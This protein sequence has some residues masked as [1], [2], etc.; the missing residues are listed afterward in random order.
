MILIGLIPVAKLA[1]ITNQTTRT[2]KTWELYHA[3]MALILEPLKVA[4][5]EGV[6]MRCADGGVRRVY[7]ILA[8][9]LGDWPKHCTV[10]ST[11]KTRCPICIVPF[12]EQGRWGTP[13]RLQ[14]KPQTVETI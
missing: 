1:W 8:A 13:A 6:E 7:P 14:T 10:G 11:F 2:Q 12:H 5:R 9:H 3:C 4:A